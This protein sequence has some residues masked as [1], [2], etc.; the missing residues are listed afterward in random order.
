MTLKESAD[1]VV[2]ELMSIWKKSGI[3]TAHDFNIKKRLLKIYF[4]NG[5]H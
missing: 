4:L 3:P 2:N 5:S 1:V